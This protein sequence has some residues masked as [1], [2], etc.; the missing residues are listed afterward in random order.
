MNREEILKKSRKGN[1]S[2]EEWENHLWL[3]S[4]NFSY[5]VMLAMWFFAIVFIR[6][7]QIYAAVG[8]MVWITMTANS[9][10]QFFKDR[11]PGR[12]VVFLLCLAILSFSYLPRFIPL[13][14]LPD[15]F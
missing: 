12:L 7:K 8:T 11:K 4:L 13:L 5:Y 10:Y 14:S 15:L 6:D 3:R 9:A 1:N 2:S